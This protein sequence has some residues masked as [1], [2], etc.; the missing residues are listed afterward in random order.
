[1]ERIIIRRLPLGLNPEH[2]IKVG[3]TAQRGGVTHTVIAHQGD[4]LLIAPTLPWDDLPIAVSADL[5]TWR[6]PGRPR[7]DGREAPLDPNSGEIAT[8][9]VM[10]GSVLYRKFDAG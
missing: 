8:S 5:K 4:D 10:P 3:A 1:M 2:P 7:T 6:V 9:P